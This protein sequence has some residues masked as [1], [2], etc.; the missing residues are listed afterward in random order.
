MDLRE[1][2]TIRKSFNLAHHKSDL[3]VRLPFSDVA[4]LALLH[5]DPDGIC[6]SELSDY[7][8]SL[9]PTTTHR[10]KRLENMGLITRGSRPGD[11]RC[12]LCS[13]TAL[14]ERVY[15]ETLHF[16]CKYFAMGK[17]LAH[18]VPARLHFYVVAM[19]SFEL[20]SAD[21]VLLSLYMREQ[22]QM[23]I[24]DIVSMVGLL[25]PT[26]SMCVVNLEKEG[27]VLRDHTPYATDFRLTEEG[28]ARVDTLKNNIEAM[29]VRRKDHPKSSRI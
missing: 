8:H 27:L 10:T 28:R 3:S 12:I 19:A 15:Q 5:A 7:Q 22:E 9:R 23:T 17:P 4:I 6:T 18:I 24:T 13:K 20:S 1:F 14:G 2:I 29:V 26:V 25:Q 21:L 16:S 11:K